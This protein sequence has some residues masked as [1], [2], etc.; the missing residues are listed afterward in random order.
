VTNRNRIIA[1]AAF[2]V[3]TG[4]SGQ[5]PPAP[6]GAET[7]PKPVVA[8]IMKS[9]ANE[10]FKTME[11]G[12]R[13]HQAAH[14]DGYELIAQG[15]KDELDVN[16]QVRLV[17]QMTAQGVDAIVIAPADSKALVSVCNRAM[18]AGVSV[19]NIDNRFDAAVLADKGIRIPFVGPDNR[20]GARMV[21]EHLAAILAP[22]DPVAI[23]EGVPTAF[24][25]QQRK[26]G[27]EDAVNARGLSLVASQSA[28]WEMA[29]ANQV[30]SA[31]ITEHPDL[32]AFLCAND[33]MALGAVSALRG[34]GK[35]DDVHVVGFDNISAVQELLKNGDILATA[36]QHAVFGIEYTLDMLRTGAVPE[37]RETPVDLVT[38]AD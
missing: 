38:A 26:T 32:K 37:D 5:Q 8:L 12:A 24:N 30:A 22:G 36:D 27:F 1:L 13:V 29:E 20:E 23:I 17:E 31:I 28:R 15:I 25:A 4:C 16:R 11:N 18:A 7:P 14:A 35:L 2:I 19:V 21:G 6:Q 33:S 10:F 3:V 9:L 34:A